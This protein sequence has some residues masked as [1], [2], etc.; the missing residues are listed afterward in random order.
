M[1]TEQEKRA[2]LEKRARAGEWLTPGEVATLLGT[3]RATVVR[4][5]NAGKLTYRHKPGT[6]HWREVDP[7]AV[8]AEYERAKTVH[9]PTAETPADEDHGRS[10]E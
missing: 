7:N 1:S 6:G 9:G 8:L 10:P 5:L 2:D 4:M 3:S